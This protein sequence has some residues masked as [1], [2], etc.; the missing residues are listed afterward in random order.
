M[1]CAAVNNCCFAYAV[2]RLSVQLTQRLFVSSF[3]AL[4][5]DAPRHG[6]CLRRVVYR[7]DIA[8]SRL[9]GQTRVKSGE[10]HLFNAQ[11]NTTTMAPLQ[12]IRK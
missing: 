12:R 6:A 5:A 2:N 11:E 9:G 8:I 10:L 3:R 1:D 7:S 4:C